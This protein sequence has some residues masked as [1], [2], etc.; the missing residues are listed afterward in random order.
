MFPLI[1]TL[2]LALVSFIS[3]AFVILRI[4]IPVLPPHPLS[5]RVPPSE[6]GL[7]NFKTLSPADKSHLWLASLDLIALIIFSWQA[8]NEY[9]G[10]VA[11]FDV[12]SDPA[13]AVRLWI[14]TTLRQTCLLVVAALTLLH[15]RMGHSVS[16]GR[17]HWML[18]VPTVL[19]MGTSTAL[20]GILAVTGVES[21]FWGLLG[22]S[23]F[24]AVLSSVAF[25]CLIGTLVIIRRN[26]TALHDMREPWPPTRADSE[27]PRASFETADVDALKDGSS[28]ITSHASSRHESIS[29]F[30]FSTH[31]THSRMHSNA[32]SRIHVNAAMASNPSIPATSSFWFNAATPGTGRMS[33]VPPVPPLP[34]PYR[35]STAQSYNV[36]NDPDPFRGPD[37]R[38]RMGSQSSWL[39][40]PSAYQPTLSAW[41]FPASAPS[42][43][44]LSTPDLHSGLLPTTDML[45]ST[46]VSRLTPAMATTDVLGGY[47]YAGEASRAESGAAVYALPG[48]E[49]DISVY[50]AI[51]WLITIWLPMVLALPYYVTINP[52]I[53]FGGPWAAYLLVISV[54]VSSPLLAANILFRSPLPIPSGL[55]DTPSD[56]PSIVMRAPSPASTF[57]HDYK[58]SGSVTVVEGRRSGDVWLANG[59]AVEGKSKLGR[60]MGLLQPKPKLSVMPLDHDDVPLTPPLPIQYPDDQPT[61][62]PTPQSA[63]NAEIGMHQEMGMRKKDSKAS[64]YYSNAE[65]TFATQIMIAQRHYSALATTMVL[66]PSPDRG[67]SLDIAATTA[68]E[69]VPAE[70]KH[71]GHLRARS[72]SSVVS[73]PRSPISGPPSSPLPPTPPTLKNFKAKAAAKRLA[74]RKSYSSTVDEFSFGPIDNDDMNEIDA[75]SA[76][77]LPLLVPGLKVGSDIKI[78]ESWKRTPSV[79][80][81]GKQRKSRVPSELG[82]VSTDSSVPFESTPYQRKAQTQ[83]KQKKTPAHK[84]HHFS[85][86]SLSL[87]KDGVH[88]LTTWRQDLNQAMENRL[89]AYE[90][91]NVRAEDDIRRN[92][93]YGGEFSSNGDTHLNVLR[94]EDESSRPASPAVNHPYSSGF[95]DTLDVPENIPHSKRNSLATLISALDQELRMPP[96]SAASEVTLFDFDP[97]AD[98]VAESTP[99]ES[100]VQPRRSTDVAPPVPPVPSKRTSIVYIKSDENAPPFATATS[101]S[102]TLEQWSTQDVQPLAPKSKRHRLKVKTSRTANQENEAPLAPSQKGLRPLSLLQ[103]QNLDFGSVTNGTQPLSVKG[104]GK[105]SKR[106]A[107]GDGENIRRESSLK[108]VFKPL[109]LVRNETTKERAA[110]RDQE[111]LP[112]VVVRPPSDTFGW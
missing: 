98:G 88:A 53:A 72:V 8:L 109:K 61:V 10:G 105:S 22:Y 20:A 39:T 21:F 3:S 112:A 75:L 42:S 82:G 28:W 63:S 102:S 77:L 90:A 5:R 91:V 6:F 19:F 108:R 93:V 81:H 107:R 37:P 103:N 78:T 15:V 9:F 29:A 43:P 7:P 46:A 70:S 54:T 1:P 4:V 92:T 48:S 84:R 71:A 44:Y 110:L 31:H 73:V 69:A 17:F 36:D 83:A 58:R 50:R 94:E 13:S 18:W 32:S 49:V 64:S 80:S 85:L 86:P 68:V 52:Q 62:P 25:A 12:A 47:G 67:S 26:L 11:G 27:K 55:F 87:G 99:H 66:P 34:A 51:G 56:P 45:P 41:S 79:T 106:A 100:K 24:V 57:A 101:S 38:P 97:S 2:A 74:H 14:A 60:A 111:I 96:P 30:S 76:G 33:P 16:F 104:K 40:E 59:D 35:P 95:A 65:E 89:S 23:T